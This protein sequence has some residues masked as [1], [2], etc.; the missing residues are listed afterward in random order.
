MPALSPHNHHIPVRFLRSELLN[1]QYSS[2]Y[3]PST[4]A[5][6]LLTALHTCDQVRGHS[7][8]G[9]KGIPSLAAVGFQ[10]ILV[11][12]LHVPCPFRAHTEGSGGGGDGPRGEALTLCSVCPTGQ[13]LR[14]HHRQLRAVLR[15]LLRGGEETSGVLCQPR[16]DAGGSTVEEPAPRRDHHPLPAL[17]PAGCPQGQVQGLLWLFSFFLRVTFSLLR[18]LPS[19]PAS[20]W[21]RLAA[22]QPAVM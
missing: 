20:P 4:G 11:A 17:R 15:P 1:T 10:C 22:P 12:V 6:M 19:W 9:E 8:P 16:H 7:S 2:L 18:A 14:V 5:L 13:C 3:M 21:S